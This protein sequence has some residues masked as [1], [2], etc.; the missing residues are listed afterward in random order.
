MT[1]TDF[2]AFLQEQGARL[3]A[4]RCESFGQA[5]A[6]S[7]AFRSGAALVPLLGMT[8]LR[9]GGA[10][11]LD[12]IHG[13]VSNE[14]KRLTE[15][16]QNTS[17]L[18]N[19][20]GHALAQM[21][22][23]RREDDLYLAVEDG[24]GA[25]VLDHFRRHIVFDQVELLD[26][27]GTILS[28]TLQGPQASGVLQTVLDLG[29]LEPGYSV[30]PPFASAKLLVLPAQRGEH[31]GYDLHV[32]AADASELFGALRRGGAVPAGEEALEASRIAAGIAKASSE[33]GEG[34]LP[35]EAGLD[36]AV[37]Y[38]KGC[39][40][41]QEIMAR[42]EARGNVRRGLAGLRYEAAPDPSDREVYLDGKAVGR[43]GHAVHHPD[44]GVIGLAVLRKDLGPSAQLAAGGV[45]ARVT[46]LPF[47]AD[48]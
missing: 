14:L 42:I 4:G 39:Y 15:G 11:R 40:L 32:L 3:A 19:V 8:P 33:G 47:S 2:P 26:L 46:A 43:R 29:A 30:Q 27:T 6:E 28:L 38:R 25:L 24:A 37:S 45:S 44:F 23:C 16:Q 9:A 35:Q 10:D 21:R 34:V 48:G 12:F 1:T 36:F 18:L 31:G 17:L 5:E 20:K 41:G 7:G 22:V 13:Q